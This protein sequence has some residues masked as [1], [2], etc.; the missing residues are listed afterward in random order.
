MNQEN[1]DKVSNRLREN[2]K[3]PLQIVSIFAPSDIWSELD[4]LD[5]AAGSLHG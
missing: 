5:A 3:R 4:R 1:E 2:L